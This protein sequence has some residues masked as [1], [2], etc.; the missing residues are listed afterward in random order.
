MH[1]LL[2]NACSAK[3][4]SQYATM[5]HRQIHLTTPPVTACTFQKRQLDRKQYQRNVLAFED[6]VAICFYQA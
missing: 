3:V 5:W 4:K 2:C 6:S 1:I